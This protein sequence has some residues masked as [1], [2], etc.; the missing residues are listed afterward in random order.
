MRWRKS[1]GRAT[2]IS[3]GLGPEG[4]GEPKKV[5]TGEGFKQIYILERPVWAGRKHRMGDM[6]EV[7]PEETP[8][9]LH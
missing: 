3:F 1:R 2:V 8:R 6:S 4:N 7:P 5:Y 9:G